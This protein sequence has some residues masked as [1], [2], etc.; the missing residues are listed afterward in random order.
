M[1]GQPRLTEQPITNPIA[2]ALEDWARETYPHLH[3]E[4]YVAL[5]VPCVGITAQRTPLPPN[6]YTTDR[7]VLNCDR[8]LLRAYGNAKEEA[9]VI[10]Y[11]DPK[12]IDKLSAILD[13]KFKK[14]WWRRLK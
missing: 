8:D 10:E 2:L 12:L 6:R 11:D 7:I 14:P 1:S 13:T 4:I 5:Y 9:W 3:V